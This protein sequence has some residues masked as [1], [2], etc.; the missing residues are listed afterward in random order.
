M[1]D[2]LKKKRW[3]LRILAGVVILV[4]VALVGLNYAQKA[5][6]GP[7]GSLLPGGEM[8]AG[9]LVTIESPD[10]SFISSQSVELQLVEP[11]SSRWVGAQWYNERLYIPCDLGFMWARL[12]GMQ[13][14]V[15]HAVYR[16]KRWHTDAVADGR[17]V[18][19]VGGKSISHSA[20]S[21]AR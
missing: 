16:L 4:T 5:S 19:R 7:Y 6:D 21:G 12:S 20:K 14:H 8:I 10:W 15:M 11:T 1:T 13:R 9:E 18:L 3:S 17:A 2:K